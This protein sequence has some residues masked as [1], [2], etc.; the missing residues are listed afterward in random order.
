[1]TKFYFSNDIPELVRNTLQIHISDFFK[2]KEVD[3]EI[4]NI[5]IFKSVD[6][7]ED[8]RLIVKNEKDESFFIKLN[9]SHENPIGYI[10]NTQYFYCP[11]IRTQD[12]VDFKFVKRNAQLIFEKIIELIKNKK[13]YSVSMSSKCLEGEIEHNFL[14]HKEGKIVNVVD[15]KESELKLLLDKGFASVL[16]KLKMDS[17]L[18]N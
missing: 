5:D 11:N 4:V 8:E 14:V 17:L 10:F 16:L 18:D 1:M 13:G 15:I 12:F 3:C 2:A 7:L 6:N 9:N